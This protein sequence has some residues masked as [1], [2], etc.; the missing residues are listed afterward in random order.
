MTAEARGGPSAFSAAPSNAG[1]ANRFSCSA[2]SEAFVILNNYP[3]N[4]GH[5]MIVPNRHVGSL[6]GLPRAS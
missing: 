1:S 2:D 4:N 5:L 6:R 3:Y